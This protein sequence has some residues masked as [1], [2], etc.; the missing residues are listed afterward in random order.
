MWMIVLSLPGTRQRSV[1]TDPALECD[2]Q[3][4]EEGEKPEVDPHVVAGVTHIGRERLEIEPNEGTLG[5]D[6]DI[7]IG[8][9]YPALLENAKVVAE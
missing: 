3:P 1:V 9:H 6:V 4:D 7:G 2:G 8:Y 5:T